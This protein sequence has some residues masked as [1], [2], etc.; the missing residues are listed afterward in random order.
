[1]S[2]RKTVPHSKV[3]TETTRSVTVRSLTS[4]KRSTAVGKGEM[5]VEDGCRCG[6]WEVRGGGGGGGS[7][8]KTK[9][10]AKF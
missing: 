6:G 8:S 5:G 1:M 7:R 10:L 9:L 2:K 4:Q 3:C